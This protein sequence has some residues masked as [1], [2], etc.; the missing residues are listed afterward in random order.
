MD[1]KKKQVTLLGPG[2]AGSQQDVSN[3]GD[4]QAGK[5]GKELDS[6]A[7]PLDVLAPRMFAFDGVFTGISLAAIIDTLPNN[8]HR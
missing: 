8:F 3:P 4:Q 6:G 7:G 1:K 5:A 2:S